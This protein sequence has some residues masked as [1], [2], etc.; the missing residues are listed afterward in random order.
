MLGNQDV[1]GYSQCPLR[2]HLTYREGFPEA[3]DT[4]ATKKPLSVRQTALPDV[5][6]GDRV[7]HRTLV[8]GGACL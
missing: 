6:S 7:A 1:S 4:A 8:C 5:T 2:P 3:R